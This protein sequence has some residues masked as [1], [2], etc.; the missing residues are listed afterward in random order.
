MNHLEDA[1][2]TARTINLSDTFSFLKRINAKR[3]F[4]IVSSFPNINGIKCEIEKDARCFKF[5]GDQLNL[6]V[7]PVKYQDENYGFGDAFALVNDAHERI[8]IKKGVGKASLKLAQG[9]ASEGEFWEIESN[10]TED[11]I[12]QRAIVPFAGFHKAPVEFIKSGSFKIGDS[13]RVA[14]FVSVNISAH[15]VGIYDY[16]FEKNRYLF[17][18]CYSAINQA[19]FQNLIASIT[20]SYA[21]ISGCLLRDEIF[22]LQ[23]KTS[24][25]EVITGYQFSRLEESRQGV[26]AIDPKM[27][28]EFYKAQTTSYMP[29]ENFQTL[30]QTSFD[31]VR[32]LRA[33]KIITES[34]GYPSEIR[35]ATY[36]V[37]LETLKNIILENNQ[38]R[39][40][41]FKNKTDAKRIIKDLKSIVNSNDDSLFN[42][43]NA[44]LTKLEH[45]NQVTNSD[46]FILA[47]KL[48]GIELS[49]EDE[50]C[51]GMRNDFLHGRIPFQNEREYNDEELNRTVFKFHYLVTSLI[52]KMIGYRGFLVN[53]LK[54]IDVLRYK[55]Y[56]PNVPLFKE[57]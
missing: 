54:M 18:D 13:L 43:K 48:L 5:R 31:D 35:T 47:F 3:S 30:I 34:F 53:N 40:N 37:A 24:A 50:E 45:L 14:G 21:L 17:I 49:T 55:R 16:D 42:N 8:E 52:F 20:Y 44:V 22:I 25:F 57:I 29:V 7:S 15:S 26:S 51:I 6:D 4:R 39:I 32:F 19:E 2:K 41:P 10:F 23:S 1:R 46:G 9:F 12:C 11:Q 27:A 33:I 28:K 56:D 36:S 38:D